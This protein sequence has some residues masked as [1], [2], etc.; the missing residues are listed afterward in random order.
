VNCWKALL[1]LS[2]YTRGKI[3]NYL[4]FAWAALTTHKKRGKK[5]DLKRRKK[6]Y[7]LFK[8]KK[9]LSFAC[10]QAQGTKRKPY[11]DKIVTK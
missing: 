9:I 7:G 2:Y 10:A 6:Y 8:F 1:A 3:L 5:N 4:T 11:K